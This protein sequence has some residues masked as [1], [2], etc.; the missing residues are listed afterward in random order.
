MEYVGEN[1][2]KEMKIHGATGDLTPSIIEW[3]KRAEVINGWQLISRMTQL[4]LQR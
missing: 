4:S 1:E 2:N 3:V